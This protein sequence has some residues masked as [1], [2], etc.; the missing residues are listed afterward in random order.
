[1]KPEASKRSPSFPDESLAGRTI[2]KS[3]EIGNFIV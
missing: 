3:K 1:M 2:E